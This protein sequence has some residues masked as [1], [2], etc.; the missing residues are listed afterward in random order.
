MRVFEFEWSWQSRPLGQPWHS[1]LLVIF[2]IAVFA[3][4]AY[5]YRTTR[6][7][8]RQAQ[9]ST[10]VVVRMIEGSDGTSRPRVRFAD[11][12]GQSHELEGR[13]MRTPPAYS[14]GEKVQVV[15][16]PGS[17]ETA[18]IDRFSELWVVSLVTGL[19]GFALT[20]AAI[21]TW[22]FRKALFR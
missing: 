11:A 13:T 10:G 20:A 21:F 12:T 19:I 17:P 22:V 6:D 9:P 3:L 15:Y 7:F 8:L 5:S 2:A 4:S 14:V 18:R 1:L 16:L